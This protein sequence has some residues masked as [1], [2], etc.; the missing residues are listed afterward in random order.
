MLYGGCSIQ[1]GTNQQPAGNIFENKY[2]TTHQQKYKIQLHNRS[3]EIGLLF[4][5]LNDF[6]LRRI[7][8]PLFQIAVIWQICR[9]RE[10]GG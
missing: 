10:G 3:I 5:S 9:L 4:H 2:F 6:I 7:I 8:L 1:M